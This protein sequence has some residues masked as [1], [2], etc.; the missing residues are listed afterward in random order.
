[1]QVLGAD[2]PGLDVFPIQAHPTAGDVEKERMD[3]EHRRL[4]AGPDHGTARDES[5]VVDPGLFPDL[6]AGASEGGFVALDVS[7]DSR[8]LPAE[9]PDSL[10]A[11]DDQDPPLVP[12]ERGHDGHERAVGIERVGLPASP[13]PGEGRRVRD[14]EEGGQQDPEPEMHR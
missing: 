4:Q 7:G 2:P 6:L 13:K 12:E 9:A 5:R 1:M 11:K 10:P 14:A 3:R 8:P